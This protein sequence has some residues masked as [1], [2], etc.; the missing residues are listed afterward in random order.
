MCK[1]P[2]GGGGS[3]ASARSREFTFDI[4]MFLSDMGL[5]CSTSNNSKSIQDRN[6][7][8]ALLKR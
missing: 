6:I 2:H 8:F 7:R 4:L 3:I 1:I 5:P